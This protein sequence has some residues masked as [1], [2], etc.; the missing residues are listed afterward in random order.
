MELVGKL[1]TELMQYFASE[2]SPVRGPGGAIAS[3]SQ[4]RKISKLLGIG[5]NTRVDLALMDVVV[6]N[7][8]ISLG[9]KY[10][11]LLLHATIHTSDALA[12]CYRYSSNAH[13]SMVK[14]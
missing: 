9:Y 10:L 13:S 11:G 6:H 3:T 7:S 12:S 5:Y 4:T 8:K 14:T 2:I 1:R